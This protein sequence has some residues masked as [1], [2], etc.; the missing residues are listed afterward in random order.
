MNDESR[1]KIP[2]K[3]AVKSYYSDKK[4]SDGQ[5]KE[6]SSLNDNL[7]SANIP[8]RVHKFG[9]FPFSAIAASIFIF[10][11]LMS[12]NKDPDIITAAYNDI[13]HDEKLSNGLSDVHKNW[14]AVNDIQAAPSDYNVEMSKFC[15]INGFKTMHLRIAGKY[16]GKMNL[17]FKK[18]TRPYWFGKS[19]GKT[20]DMNWKVLE[21]SKDITVI[22]MY[23][24]DMRENVVNNIIEEMLPDLVA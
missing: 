14:I 7:V 17:F 22:V 18:G 8:L 19:S 11:A 13:I 16:Q 2:L 12:Y 4:L 24:K 3:K 10:I 5:L 6:L 20:K 21:S 1:E 15:N 9:I 23:T